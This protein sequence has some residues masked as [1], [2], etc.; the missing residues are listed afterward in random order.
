METSK[1][2]LITT[3]ESNFDGRFLGFKPIQQIYDWDVCRFWLKKHFNDIFQDGDK[4]FESLIEQY[5]NSLFTQFGILDPDTDNEY[6]I[7]TYHI[8]KEF[9]Q[10]YVDSDQIF[11]SDYCHLVCHYIILL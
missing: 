6:R 2:V 7:D 9:V 4:Q 10:D 3:K 1:R 5:N 11:L 8:A